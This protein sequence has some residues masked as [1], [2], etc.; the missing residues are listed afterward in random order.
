MQILDQLRAERAD[1][2]RPALCDAVGVAAVG[3]QVA[4][5]G[6]AG[7]H[8]LDDGHDRGRR[9]VL[10]GGEL[11]PPDQFGDLGAVLVADGREGL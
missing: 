8:A 11:R 10:A 2:E 3:E 9:V 1:W 4:D 7:G 5:P 6:A